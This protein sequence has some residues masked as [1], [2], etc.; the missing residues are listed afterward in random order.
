MVQSS[1]PNALMILRESSLREVTPNAT[2][3][4]VQ[5]ITIKTGPWSAEPESPMLNK[6]IDRKKRVK[7][8][9]NHQVWDSSPHGS[10]RIL[11]EAQGIRFACTAFPAT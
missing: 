11:P 5:N 4:K 9:F 7:G 8:K 6:S 2:R 10:R 3:Q 1:Q